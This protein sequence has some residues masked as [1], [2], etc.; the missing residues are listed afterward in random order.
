MNVT[1][2]KTLK[3]LTL[4]IGL[5]LAIFGLIVSTHGFGIVHNISWGESDAIRGIGEL[6][7]GITLLLLGNI[8]M[9]IGRP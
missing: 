8:L 6:L 5:I 7:F 4:A 3:N 9:T 1:S 2:A